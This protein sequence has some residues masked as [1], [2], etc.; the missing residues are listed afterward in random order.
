VFAGDKGAGKTTLALDVVVRHGFEYISNDHL[1][2]YRDA[3]EGGLV[4][5]SLPTPIPVK[6][7]TY[8]AMENA[9]PVPW[10]TNQVDVDAYRG[11]PTDELR[12]LDVR[13][14]YTFASFGQA[15]PVAIGCGGTSNT[16]VVV[17]LPH[18]AA[19][20]QE[21]RPGGTASE[22]LAHLRTDWVF[23]PVY[24]PRRLPYPRRT[25]ERFTRD[26]HDLVG[27]L[28]A[29]AELMTWAHNGA[30]A[31]LLDALTAGGEA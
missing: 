1:I 18:F 30:V 23:S 3:Q 25:V 13:L 20:G 6:I 9:L 2:L 12:G 17:V 26:A 31:S 24:N 27:S 22:V 5:T 29:G 8:L 14:D 10:N 28:C 11:W 19:G 16:R 4:V 21:P 15:N 7:G